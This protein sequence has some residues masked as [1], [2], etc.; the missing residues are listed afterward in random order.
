VRTGIDLGAAIGWG[1]EGGVIRGNAVGDGR[2]LGGC[3]GEGFVEIVREERVKGEGRE[4]EIED[5]VTEDKENSVGEVTV[6]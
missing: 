1:L 6:L 2:L 3:P 5:S 4:D